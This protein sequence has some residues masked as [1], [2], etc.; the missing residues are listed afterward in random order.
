[1][2]PKFE[3]TEEG[4][5]IID[6]IE[7]HRYQLTTNEPV[8]LESA[9]I[10]QIGFPVGSVVQFTAGS[11]ELSTTESVLV[12]DSDSS[13]LAQVGPAKQA[14]FQ[15]DRYT[16]DISGPLKVYAHVDSPV[17]IY[18][19]DNNTYINFDGETNVVLGARSFHEQ[20]AGT[21]TTTTDPQDVMEAVSA[22]GSALKT[23]TPERAYPTLRGHPPRLELGDDLHI[24][25]EFNQTEQDVHI[26]VPETLHHV[27]IVAPLAYYLGADVISGSTPQIVT[28]RGYT[29]R[30]DRADGF[31]L[32]VR[33]VLKQIF[34][35]DCVIRTE[36]TTPLPLYERQAVESVLDFDFKTVYNQPLTDRI[37]TYLNLPY[38]TLKPYIPDW[39]FEAEFEP[40]KDH[41]QFLPFLA[42]DLTVISAQEE[43]VG[44]TLPDSVAEQAIEDFTR[45][46]FVRS[47]RSR[48]N[49]GN[50]TIEKTTG[51]RQ[52]LTIQQSWTG[53]NNS[54]VVSTTPLSAYQNNIGRTPKDGPIEIK[55]ICN[56]SDM[57]E[58]LE[59]VN[60]TYGTREELPFEITVHYDL[61]M[62]DLEDVLARDCDFL[63]YIG[64]IDEGG[65]QCSDGKLDAATINTVGAKAFLLNAC[66]S[67]NQGLHLIESG[68]IGGIVTLGNVV[69]SG[70]VSIGSLIARL[71]DLGFPLYAALDIARQE[72]VVG[73]Q[74]L[75][76]GD[77]KTTIAQSETRAPNVC[78]IGESLPEITL[79]IVSYT[80]AEVK[81][82]GVF[83]P[84]IESVES[85]YVLPRESGYIS[86]TR[87]ELDEFFDEALFPVIKDN[88]VQWSK[89]L[90]EK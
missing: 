10:D 29:Y 51:P 76:V 90:L 65:F 1:M 75:M 21:I 79:N 34:F 64:H 68:S 59:S 66:Q 54:D 43:E 9:S 17:Q 62:S 74:Y 41:V 45:D 73:Q 11:I 78:L 33:Q 69:N 72:N 86:V 25:E 26:E 89:D 87:P 81:K 60:S 83:S 56:D 80:S 40:T 30:L 48:S 27:F 49:R 39:R 20:P 23:T 6:P 52:E 82:G 32:S 24:P 53:I 2:K 18:S 42:N 31:E 12:R 37:E 85:F 63:H 71:L 88:Q 22:F 58:E 38:S 5:E 61:S 3:P 47:T 46:D 35:L 55:V 14:S 28:E 15:P 8:S 19:D 50:K 4:I 57:R 16:L 84:H 67:H 36:G 70:A 44:P 13:M 7:R 77:G